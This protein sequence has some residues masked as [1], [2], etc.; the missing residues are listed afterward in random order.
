MP[1]KKQVLLRWQNASESTKELP[2][3]ES[4]KELPTSESTNELP[5]SESTKELPTSESN[6][7]MM[8]IEKSRKLNVGEVESGRSSPLFEDFS[9]NE[10]FEEEQKKSLSSVPEVGETTIEEQVES[11]GECTCVQCAQV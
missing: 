4:T 1:Y 7:H 3:L 10:D 9:D 11:A 8:E 2:I 5:T 6:I